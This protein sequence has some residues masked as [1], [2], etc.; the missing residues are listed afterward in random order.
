[1]NTEKTQIGVAI[2]G[3]GNISTSYAEQILNYLEIKLL[4]FSDLDLSRAQECVQNYGGKVYA[5]LDELLGD[6]EVD[7]VVNL[8]IHIAHA[9]VIRKCLE[10]GKHVHSE[11]P[12]SM[13]SKEAWGLVKLAEEKGLR[14]SSSPITYM[15]E[16]QDAAWS[17]INSGKLGTVRLVYAEVNHGFIEV[18]HPNPLPFYDL[19]AL[20]DVGVYPLTLMTA[21]FGPVRRVLG[22]SKVLKKDHVTMNDEP[23]SITTPDFYHGIIEMASGVT[24]R[25]TANFYAKM[26]YQGGSLEFHGDE[27][28]LKLGDFQNFNAPVELGEYGE[29][30]RKVNHNGVGEEKYI[31]FSR[32]VQDMAGAILEDRPT[33]SSPTQAAHVI[34][35]IVALLKSMETG[36]FV[37]VDSDFVP[38]VPMKYEYS[39]EAPAETI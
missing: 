4:G 39:V 13:T 1:M 2:V 35:V 12:I 32:G 24:C 36:E 33:R 5:D 17:V 26:S 3:C 28:R 18:W 20:W 27:G 38:P 21:F 15:G 25:L 19:G 30:Y 8:T 29:P 34:D 7:I 11:K 9:E 23:F 16:A 37:G 22:Y 10:A 6:P 31:E 14:F